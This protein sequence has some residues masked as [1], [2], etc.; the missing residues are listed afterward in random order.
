VHRTIGE[1]DQDGG[2][3]VAALAAPASAATAA[4]TAESEAA[5]RIET[6]PASAWAESAEPARKTGTERAVPVGAVLAHVLAEIATSLS[7]VFVKGA[8][9][10]RVEAEAESAWCW[11]EWVVHW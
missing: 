11:C 6:E 5:A 9:L 4:W 10:L 7:M 3:D 1:Q 2:A 8:A